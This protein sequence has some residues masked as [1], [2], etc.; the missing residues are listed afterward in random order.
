MTTGHRKKRVKTKQCLATGRNGKDF[1]SVQ[2]GYTVLLVTRT[3]LMMINETKQNT[4][5]Q[6]NRLICY[7]GIFS[8]EKYIKPAEK[9]NN[10]TH[11]RKQLI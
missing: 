5:F 10:E 3:T 9:D 2:S 6:T 1:E 8:A 7:G 4:E 11:R